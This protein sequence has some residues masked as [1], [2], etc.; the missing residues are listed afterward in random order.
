MYRLTGVFFQVCAS[1]INRFI[2]AIF[3]LNDYLSTADDG[4]FKLTNLVALGKIGIKIIFPRS[5]RVP[6]NFS[7]NSKAEF[8]CTVDHGFIY[9][10]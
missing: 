3:Q 6:G 4:K 10:G 5:H 2:A 7:I 8:D 9:N 1:N